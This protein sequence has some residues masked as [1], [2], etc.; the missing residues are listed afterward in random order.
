MTW[1]EVFYLLI[2]KIYENELLMNRYSDKYIQ[3]KNLRIRN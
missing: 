2:D 1:L 3:Y